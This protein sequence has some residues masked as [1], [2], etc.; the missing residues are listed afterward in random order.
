MFQEVFLFEKAER[1]NVKG[2]KYLGSPVKYYAED[3][4]LRNARLNFLQVERIHLVENV[5]YYIICSVA[6]RADMIYYSTT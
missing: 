6:E 4:G 3:T 1:W 2:R 5:I